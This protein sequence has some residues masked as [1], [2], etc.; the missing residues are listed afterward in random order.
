MLPYH[1]QAMGFPKRRF[2]TASH[3]SEG[4]TGM[5]SSSARLRSSLLES[6]S[7][8]I[9]VQSR[10]STPHLF[11]LFGEHFNVEGVLASPRGRLVP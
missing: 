9:P 8:S 5:G 6:Q 3:G 11:L 1:N 4:D 10:G 2:V 7:D